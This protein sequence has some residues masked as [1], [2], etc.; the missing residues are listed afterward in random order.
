[1]K[2]EKATG[3]TISKNAGNCITIRTNVNNMLEFIHIF[4]GVYR[5]GMITIDNTNDSDKETI[6]RYKEE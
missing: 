3:K 1:M 6:V 2:I 4:N 5:I